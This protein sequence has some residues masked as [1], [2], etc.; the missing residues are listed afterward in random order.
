M[1]YSSGSNVSI[2]Y[3]TIYLDATPTITTAI[4]NAIPTTTIRDASPTTTISDVSLP[5]PS[6]S[7]LVPQTAIPTTTTSDA[8]LHYTGFVTSFNSF[9]LGPV[10][11]VPSSHFIIREHLWGAPYL[12]KHQG[13]LSCLLKVH[14]S[15]L[16][17]KK[18]QNH[19]GL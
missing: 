12:R 9:K 2:Q 7:S 14:Q 1:P 3:T 4:R 17:D 6:V 8:S 18:R 19:Q 11:V 15:V 10:P 5:R 13:E 16:G